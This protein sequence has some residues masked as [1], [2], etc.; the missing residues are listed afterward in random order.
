MPTR[1]VFKDLVEILY[2]LD[3]VDEILLIHIRTDL[4]SLEIVEREREIMK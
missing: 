2:G 4:I 3:G 1:G